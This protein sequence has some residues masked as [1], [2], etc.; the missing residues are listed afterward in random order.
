MR[1]L[2]FALCIIGL[3]CAS[4]TP[5][6]APDLDCRNFTKE[7]ATSRFVEGLRAAGTPFTVDPDRGIGFQIGD[8]DR[9]KF[10]RL[11]E[12]ASD[13]VAHDL[14]YQETQSGP[15]DDAAQKRLRESASQF[16]E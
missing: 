1:R 16:R 5:A 4:P 11:V 2:A 15:P 13:R 8:K 6:S 7:M 10:N 12:E 3:S 14:I 9:E